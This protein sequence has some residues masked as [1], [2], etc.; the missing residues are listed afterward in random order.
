M[1]ILKMHDE[2]PFC[3]GNRRAVHK[4]RVCVSLM[5]M[6]R[7]VL[8]SWKKIDEK[9]ATLLSHERHT[10]LGKTGRI[11]KFIKIYDVVDIEKRSCLN[12]LTLLFDIVYT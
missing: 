11:A 2:A 5:S 12:C 10:F 3:L 9:R 6:I 4:Y 7:R 8:N 1:C